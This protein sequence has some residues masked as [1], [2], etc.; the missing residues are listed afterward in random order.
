MTERCQKRRAKGRCGLK[1]VAWRIQVEAKDSR[2]F[3]RRV[4]PVCLSHVWPPAR[5]AFILRAQ[6]DSGA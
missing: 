4:I 3:I 6:G 1:V 2:L 5:S